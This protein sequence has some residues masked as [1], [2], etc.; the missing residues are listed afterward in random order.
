MSS[1]PTPKAFSQLDPGGVLRNSHEIQ[2]EAL[3]TLDVSNLVEG[4]FTRADVTYNGQGSAT[5][6]IFYYD[7]TYHKETIFVTEDI[8]GSLNSKYFLINGP[9]S[10]NLYYVWY[11]VDSSGVDPLISGREAIE[12]PISSNDSKSIVALATTL[13]MG[14][15][16]NFSIDF[17]I[18]NTNTEVIIQSKILGQASVTNNNTPFVFQ[19]DSQGETFV[20]KEIELPYENGVKYIYNE[21]EKTFS[22]FPQSSSSAITEYVED[23]PHSPGSTGP[24]VLGLRRDSDTSPVSQDGDY[25]GMVYDNLGNLKTKDKQAIDELVDVNTTLTNLDSKFNT[26]G[27]KTSAQSVPVVIASDQ[28]ITVDVSSP[29]LIKGTEDGTD[30]GTSHVAKIG[31]DLNLRFKD[32]SANTTLNNISTKL[33]S[34]SVNSLAIGTDNGLTTGNQFVFVNNIKNQILDAEDRQQSITYADFG[35]KNERV[36]QIDYSSVTIS[37]S[38]LARKTFNYTL[39]SG[40]YR[41]DSINWD[42]V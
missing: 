11:N 37:N 25:H 18:T 31:S 19:V 27:Q 35:T 4:Y 5:S 38:V 8:A 9:I 30:S 28:S 13:A 39:I 36:T 20:V 2:A 22:I 14:L 23:L 15:N 7:K 21:F 6:A 26:L 29:I 32:D 41:L 1:Y 42:I 12:V 40:K 24:Y 33:D 17:T 16:S 10:K 34:L 3:R